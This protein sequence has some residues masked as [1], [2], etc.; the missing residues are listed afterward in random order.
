MT[1]Q[2]DSGTIARLTQAV[3]NFQTRY[4][5][6]M[7]P[8]YGAAIFR[9]GDYQLRIDLGKEMAAAENMKRRIEKVTG[10]WTNIRGWSGL[11]AIPLVPIA[12]ALALIAAIAATAKSIDSFTTRADIKLALAND[13]ELTYEQAANQVERAHQSDFGKA[14]DLAQ[15]GLYVAGAFLFYKILVRR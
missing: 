4:D 14:I 8:S 9:T 2:A 5:K 11:G 3:E 6:L 15:L 12:I 10:A 7:D 1:D 13:P